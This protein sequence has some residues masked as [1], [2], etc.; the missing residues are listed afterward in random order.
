LVQLLAWVALGFASALAVGYDILARGYRQRMGMMDA[1]WPIT[2][3][4]FGPMSIWGYLR[5]GRPRSVK[6]S[7]QPRPHPRLLTAYPVNRWLVKIGQGR[8]VTGDRAAT[9]CARFAS[10][11]A[12]RSLSAFQ[13]G[14]P[15]ATASTIAPPPRVEP[16]TGEL[17]AL[18]LRCL[19]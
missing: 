19:L 18:R 14:V 3:L 2:A 11:D 8:H 5:L 10:V 12:A 9:S 13:V 16:V 6:A 1:V 4:Y 17:R 15:V 7:E